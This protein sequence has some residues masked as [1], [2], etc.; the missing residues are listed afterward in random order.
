MD[1]VNYERNYLKLNRLE[2]YLLKLVIP[3]IRIAHCPRGRY[4]KVKG[5]LILISSDVSTSLEKILPLQQS[6]IPVCF[7]RKVSYTGSF[8]EEYIEK[9]K[10]QMY[11]TWLKKNNHLYKDINLDKE[12]IEDFV[13]ESKSASEEFELKTK[14]NEERNCSFEIEQDEDEDFSKAFTDTPFEVYETTENNQSDKAH[15]QT[16]I[17]M[18]CPTLLMKLSTVYEHHYIILLYR[19][20]GFISLKCIT[21]LHGTIEM[22]F[23]QRVI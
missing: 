21:E 13:N 2:G 6:L 19:F 18:S 1:K 7:R 3:F 14:E 17:F 12:L 5:D 10:V 16:T 22:H 15:D 11:F 4:F 20:P 23:P 9:E 8:I